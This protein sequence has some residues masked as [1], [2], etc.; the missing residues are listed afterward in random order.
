MVLVPHY[1]RAKKILCTYLIFIIVLNYY[2]K[3]F[4]FSIS[5]ASNTN[6]KSGRPIKP[7]SLTIRPYCSCNCPDTLAKSEI[8]YC[9]IT[10]NNLKIN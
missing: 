9:P 3:K 8:L 5:S 10:G 1:D 6:S 2:K 4:T 7:P